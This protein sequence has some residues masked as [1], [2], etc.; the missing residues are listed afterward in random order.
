L[1]TAHDLTLN[2]AHATLNDYGTLLLSG[3]LDLD[4]GTFHLAGGGLQT[5][6]AFDIA[7]GATFNGY[8]TVSSSVGSMTV[9]GTVTASDATSGHVLDFASNV[10][11]GGNFQIAAGATLEFGSSVASGTTVTF[12]GLTGE[13]KLDN[14]T[15][16][17]GTIAGFHGT[18]GDAQHSD[19]I[20]LA[21]IDF[22][23]GHFTNSYAG[24]VLTVSD[25]THTANLTFANFSDTFVF[26]TDGNGGTLV[27]DPPAATPNAATDLGSNFAFLPGLGAGTTTILDTSHDPVGLAP[28]VEQL[29]SL[30]TTDSYTTAAIDLGH[31]TAVPVMSPQ[32]LQ[33]VLG[34]AVHLH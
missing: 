27:F 26:K 19:V 2:D 11:G 14:P 29:N 22:N 5:G 25:G 33:A 3:G 31:D 7:S 32:Q 34:N 18:S 13:L 12:Q 28:T 21:G 24:G 1:A 15:N 6:A 8:G 23:S 20:D 17:N 4:A 10:T 9:T 16:F 30:V